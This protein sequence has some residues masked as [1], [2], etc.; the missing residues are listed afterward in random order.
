M[1]FNEPKTNTKQMAKYEKYKIPI[2]LI[3]RFE[4]IPQWIKYI[5]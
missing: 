4:N 5:K 3:S 2:I 1:K